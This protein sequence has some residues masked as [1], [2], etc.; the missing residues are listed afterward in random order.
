MASLNPDYCLSMRHAHKQSPAF[1]HAR[2]GVHSYATRRESC[3]NLDAHGVAHLFERWKAALAT[4]DADAVAALYS[5]DAVLLPTFSSGPLKGRA[6]I[7]GYFRHFLQ[8]QPQG[9]IDHRSMKLGCNMAADVGL[10]T[11]S[12]VQTDGSIAEVPARYS[13]LYQYRNGEWLIVHHHSAV[14][15]EA[16]ASPKQAVSIQTVPQAR[17]PFAACGGPH[18]RPTTGRLLHTDSP[19][20]H[21]PSHPP[22][23]QETP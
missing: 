20:A 11:F 23:P 8:K 12:V 4:G 10:Y 7:A 6:A 9:R 3:A 2:P 22:Q 13:F 16:G 1:N 21:G 18:P 14:L 5:E 19:D 15:P 17:F